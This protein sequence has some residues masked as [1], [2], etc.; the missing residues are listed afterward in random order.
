[1]NTKNL[2]MR[3]KR[4]LRKTSKLNKNG[5]LTAAALIFIAITQVP[6]AIINTAQVVCIGQ[7]SNKVWRMENNH[8]EANMIAIQRCNGQR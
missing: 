7:M 6:G 3:F 4:L 5:V 2:S 8:L 1:M